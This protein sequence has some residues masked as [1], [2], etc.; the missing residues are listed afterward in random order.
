LPPEAARAERARA[1]RIADVA[2]WYGERAGGITTYLDA[3][4]EFA[5]RTGLFEHH[6]V[7]PGKRDLSRGSRHEVGALRVATANGYHLPLRTSSLSQALRAVAP[8]VV[9]VHDRFWSLMAAGPVAADLR[10]PVVAVHHASAALEAAAIPGP[11]GAYGKVFRSWERRAYGRVDAVMSAT[12]DAAVGGRPLLPLRFGLDPAFRPQDGVLR[13]R[14]VLYVGRFAREKGIDTLVAAAAASVDPWRLVL[15][16]DGPSRGWVE[17]L[18]ARL[19]LTPRVSLLGYV[20]DREHLARTYAAA[21]CV[22]VPGAHETFGLVA[23]EAAASGA[24][25]VAA[26]RTPAALTAGPELVT[27]FEPGDPGAL[28]RAIEHARWAPRDLG[29]A[30]RLAARSSWDRAFEAELSDLERLLG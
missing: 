24:R 10:T 2:V 12:G 9:L 14:H 16:G 18:V 29:A 26:D 13:G 30:A 11:R 27:T 7:V 19:G 5:E 20:D 1:L 28:L 17:G 25:V 15:V 4:A 3:K 23:L 8:D 6:L 22:V 21:S